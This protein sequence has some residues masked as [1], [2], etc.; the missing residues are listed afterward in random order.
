MPTLALLLWVV[1]TLIWWAFA[2]TPLPSEP[3]AWLSAARHACFGSA[4]DGLPA[5]H[6]WMLL[7]LGPA[8]FLLGIV[9]L[10][11]REL[12]SSL[13]RAVRG[14][15][16]RL[17]MVALALAV[18]FEGTWVLRKVE[19]ARAI[20]AWADVQDEAALPIDYPRQDAP[21]PDFSLVDQH[22]DVVS[23]GSLRGGPVVLTFVFAHC[24]TVCPL[25]VDKLKQASQESAGTRV[26]LVTLDAWR[27]T[28]GSLPGIARQWALPRGFHVLSS[29]D[30]AEALAVSA[31][32]GVASARDERTGDITHPGLVFLIDADG[33]LAYTFSNPSAGWVREA[34][35]RLGPIH[36]RAR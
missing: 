30:V 34:L 7:T 25:L 21:A 36:V 13:A 8:S 31:H 15:G 6:G 35:R 20:A 3:P 14:H 26:L 29:R 11:G 19:A 12:P 9:A 32:Y 28:P 2:F 24:Q 10:W 23:L 33:R 16:G 18:A 4:D 1:A 27:D 5:P 17:V 22:G